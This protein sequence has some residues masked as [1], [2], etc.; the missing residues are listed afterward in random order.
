[1]SSIVMTTTMGPAFWIIYIIFIGAL[2]YFMAIRPQRKQKK[3][4]EEMMSTLEIGDSI[5]TSGGFYGEVIDIT[6]DM[7]IVEFGSNKNCRIPM[8]KTAI[9]EIEK[10]SDGQTASV[11][12]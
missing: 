5:K 11:E 1:M 4:F 7:V 12:S 3:A 8:D 9:V 10:A 2:L 6:E